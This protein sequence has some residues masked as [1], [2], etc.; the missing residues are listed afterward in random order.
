MTNTLH[1]AEISHTGFA[2]I[3]E[4]S[5][6]EIYLF[7]AKTLRFILVNKGA[8]SNLGYSMEELSNFTPLDLKPDFTAESFAKILE[9]LLKFEKQK[10]QFETVHRRND[11]SF[12]DV[13][14]HL[15]LSTFQPVPVFVAIILDITERKKAEKKLLETQQML[16]LVMDNIPQSIFWKD[17]K[18]VYLGCN[19]NFAKEAGIKS[20]A[21]I[22]GKTD[23]DLA[24]RKEE[25]EFYRKCDKR[26]MDTNKAEYHIIEPQLQADGKQAWLDTNKIPLCDTEGKVIGILGTYEDITERRMME[27]KLLEL[28]THLKM[29]DK[30]K[31]EFLSTVAHEIRT[32]LSLVLGFVSVIN[33]KLNA[34]IFPQIKNEDLLMKKARE[35]IENNI[36]IIQTE[37]KRFVALLDDLLYITKIED[38]MVEKVKKPVSIV[39]VAERSMKMISN[40]AERKNLEIKKDFK[41]ELPLILANKAQLQQVLT[42]LINNAIKFTEKGSVTLKVG[43]QKNEIVVNVI[44]TGIGIEK[45]H[46][47]KIFNKFYQVR[48]INTG[49]R[50]GTGLGLSICKQIIENHD[51]RIWL[52]SETG[53]G[54]TFSFALPLIKQTTPN[55]IP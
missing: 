35:Q 44:D 42:N 45:E 6:N 29:Q 14:V 52:E 51:G 28:N 48:D 36:K 8:R 19:K 39:S 16:N 32:P 27:Y 20:V 4:E 33:K 18:C 41:D 10:I 30:L 13:E 47:D 37:G 9:P 46:Q 43:K 3:L 34:V 55:N 7:D 53:T 40:L 17:K 15:Q 12:Y 1:Q 38:G 31:T 11:G 23:Y 50:K 54:S 26:V 49:T 21:D 5:L 25:T 2:H 24:W 22:I